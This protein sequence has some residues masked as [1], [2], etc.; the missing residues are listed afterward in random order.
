MA[1]II[2]LAI[3]TLLAILAIVI[4]SGLM[5][6][7]AEVR[8][9]WSSLDTLLIER[10][11]LLPGL[12]EPCAHHM[13]YEQDALDR[14]SRADAAVIIAA[15]REDIPALAAAEKSLQ[16]SIARLLALA[17]NYPQL[18]ADPA[19]RGLRERIGQLDEAIRERRE[20]Y[21]FAANLQNVR[22]QSFPHRLIARFIGFHPA[23]LLE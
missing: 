4:R 21:N 20:H 16:G 11:D 7:R 3:A 12:L 8:Q 5:R 23:A 22:S 1:W 2:V 9:S 6:V 15:A 14:V 10:H 13:R 18:G 19:F 17:D